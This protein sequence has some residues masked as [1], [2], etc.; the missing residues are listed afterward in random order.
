MHKI[1]RTSGV[2]PGIIALIL[3]YPMFR[4]KVIV[5]SRNQEHKQHL[6]PI[7]LHLVTS[8]VHSCN[9]LDKHYKMYSEE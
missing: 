5:F 9:Y 6:N 4:E 8:K 2:K 7:S 1:N 3:Q